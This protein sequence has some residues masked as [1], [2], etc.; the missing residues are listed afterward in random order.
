ML[1]YE[2]LNSFT[3]RVLTLDQSI[4]W[5]GITNK[6]SVLLTGEVKQGIDLSLTEEENE[7]FSSSSITRYMSLKRVSPKIGKTIYAFGRY[8]NFCRATVP[9]SDQ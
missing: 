6:F 4:S 7:D 1:D 5:V 8:R 3:E 2:F 9:I